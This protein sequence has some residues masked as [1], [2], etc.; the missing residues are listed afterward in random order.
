MNVTVVWWTQ[1]DCKF[2][3]LTNVSPEDFEK[4][5]SFNQRFINMRDDEGIYEFFYNTET[6]E[7]KYPLVDGPIL[8]TPAFHAVVITGFCL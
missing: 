3:Q 7:M 6:H 1:E 8:D 5:I 2:I 4:L